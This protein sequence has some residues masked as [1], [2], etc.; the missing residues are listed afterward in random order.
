M[1]ATQASIGFALGL[2]GS[3]HCL[4]MCGPMAMAVGMSGGQVA[5]HLGRVATYS[6]LGG[7]AGALGAAISGLARYENAAAVLAGL[8][9]IAGAIGTA[10][11]PVNLQ[12]TNIQKRS[13]RFLLS[14]LLRHKL[15][16]GL[17]MGFLPCGMVYAALLAA[18]GSGNW[19]GGAVTMAAFGVVTTGPLLA[20]S[21]LVGPRIRQ[22]APRLTPVAMALMGVVLLWRGL[23]TVGMASHVHH[24]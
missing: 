3:L 5:Y 17:M 16:F 18:A 4:G 12:L 7:I 6:L 11:R 8:V 2:A 22:W 20:A 15:T 14:P 23:A 9:M 24:H 21:T 10:R 13:G 19:A 1:I